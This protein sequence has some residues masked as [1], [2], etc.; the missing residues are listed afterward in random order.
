MAKRNRKLVYCK[1]G[2]VEKTKEY[3][4]IIIYIYKYMKFLIF[5]NGQMGQAF[6]SFLSKQAGEEVKI[7]VGVDIR[8]KEDVDRVVGE[9]R[10]D[11]IINCAGKT[12]LD[13]CEENRLECFNVNTIGSNVVGEIAQ[14]RGVYLVHLSS[15]CL[16]ESLTA[17]EAHKEEDPPHPTSY[18]SWTKVWAENLLLECARRKNLKV[19]IIRGRQLVSAVA[20]PRNALTKMLTYTKFVDTPNSIT[21]VE[22]M[23]DATYQLIKKKATGVYNIANPGIMSPYRIAELLK[24]LVRPD[25]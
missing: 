24:E 14:N 4:E 1:R 25:M 19:L 11:A 5:G 12:N 21:V 7:A 16:Q 3:V 6:H 9:E 18:Y 13:W 22:D 10:P 15:G 20:S 2:L 17:E 23:V 8:N